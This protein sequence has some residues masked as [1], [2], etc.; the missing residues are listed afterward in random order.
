MAQQVI[1]FDAP[2]GLSIT[3]KLFERAKDTVL[4][5]LTATERT[6]KKGFYTVT[7]DATYDGQYDYAIFV[8]G[9]CIGSGQ[10]DLG[11]DTMTRQ[12]VGIH[13]G[14]DR[15]FEAKAS[16]PVVHV[17]SGESNLVKFTMLNNAG[18]VA[19]V[20]W[21]WDGG[22][23]RLELRKEGSSPVVLSTPTWDS[24]TKVNRVTLTSAQI[25]NLAS[26]YDVRYFATAGGPT[27]DWVSNGSKY[28]DQIIVGDSPIFWVAIAEPPSG[29]SVSITYPLASTIA[30]RVRQSKI[31]LYTMETLDVSVHIF[32]GN[33]D[34]VDL[35]SLGDLV[36]VIADAKRNNLMEIVDADISISGT[37]D[38]VAT[39]TVDDSVTSREGQVLRWSLRTV[40][41]NQL[42]GHGTL[43]VVYA[44][45]VAS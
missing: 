13:G 28:D 19:E 40:A 30:E 16:L 41:G 35:N 38:N 43:E 1:E 5:T 39:V 18:R 11:N 27:S 42:V 6:N 24:V 9:S 34:P 25:A 32:D 17:V 33:D 20:E 37:D 29:S 22:Y 21:G 2:S 12:A 36:F 44:P 10:V 26:G 3:L 15:L 23:P 14:T 7:F 45:I 4:Q 8:S 31:T